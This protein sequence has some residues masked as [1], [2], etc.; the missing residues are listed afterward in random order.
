MSGMLGGWRAGWRSGYD[1]LWSR[2]VGRLLSWVLVAPI[3]VYQHV[4]SP[5]LPS[6]C[7]YHPSCSAYATVALRTHGPFKGSLLA[8]ARLLRCNP[9]SA[10]GVNPVPSRGKW[11]ADVLPDGSTR[12]HAASV[13]SATTRSSAPTTPEGV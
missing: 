2:G 8:V 6:T 4:L 1:L 9:W 13:L 5:L 3:K 11:R 12:T 7:R 10:G